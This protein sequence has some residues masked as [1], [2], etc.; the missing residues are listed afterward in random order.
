MQV[1]AAGDDVGP[2]LDH[3]MHDAACHGAVEVQG[4]FELHLVPQLRKRRCRLIHPDWAHVRT[5]DPTLRSAVL[6]GNS[7]LTRLD[8]EWWM[9]PASVR[10][11]EALRLASPSAD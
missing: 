3:L 8:G 4:R 6:A 10:S 11:D 1:A 9:R 2:V 5:D 7:L